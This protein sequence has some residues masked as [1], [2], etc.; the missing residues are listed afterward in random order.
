MERAGSDRDPAMQTHEMTVSPRGVAV[1]GQ[2]DRPAS[3]L[4]C[5]IPPSVP[6]LQ[7]GGND[8]YCGRPVAHGF[9][10]YLRGTVTSW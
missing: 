1:Y 2:A 8:R 9:T 6:P 3:L 4:P 7:K 5:R 10:E